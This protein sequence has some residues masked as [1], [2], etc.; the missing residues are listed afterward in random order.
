MNLP[1]EF[2]GMKKIFF[3]SPFLLDS[4]FLSVLREVVSGDMAA[5]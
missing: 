1:T 2:K 5:F 4:L 3:C